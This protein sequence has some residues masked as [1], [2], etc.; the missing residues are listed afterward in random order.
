MIVKCGDLLNVQRNGQFI[1]PVKKF[2]AD[3]FETF[4]CD[5][6]FRQRDRRSSLLFSIRF[7][8]NHFIFSD[9]EPAWYRKLDLIGVKDLGFVTISLNPQILRK[10]YTISWFLM[11]V[12]A[13]HITFGQISSSVLS[14]IVL[15]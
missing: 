14:F 9:L 11:Q 1:K 2:F 6:T 5:A 8:S 15:I 10:V 13:L 3:F 12:R 7:S 4:L